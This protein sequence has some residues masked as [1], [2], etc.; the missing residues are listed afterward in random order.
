MLPRRK[1]LYLA[2]AAAALPAMPLLAVAQRKGIKEQIV[3]TWSLVS[4]A[5]T[6]TDGNVRNL[7]GENPKGVNI[8]TADGQFVLLFMRRDLPRIAGG[9]RTKM[10]P[11][12]ALAAVRGSL[13]YFGSYTTDEPTKALVLRFQGATFANLVGAEQTRIISF[14]SADELKYRNPGPLAG[15]FVEAAFKRAQ[16]ASWHQGCHDNEL[17]SLVS[18]L[19]QRGM[20]GRHRVRC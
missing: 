4:Q 3:G 11:E 16:Q 12:E 7:Y 10:T 2:A 19:R 1:F 6:L 14:L 13:G 9:D 15:G 20:F 17:G 8:F 18:R 5:H